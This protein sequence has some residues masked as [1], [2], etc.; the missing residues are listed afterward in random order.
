MQ[1]H[2]ILI[3]SYENWFKKICSWNTGVLKS[4]SFEFDNVESETEEILSFVYF[5]SHHA[6]DI[7][8][9]LH[10][11]R[12]VWFKNSKFSLDINVSIPK[13]ILTLLFFNRYAKGC[14]IVC[15]ADHFDKP[16]LEL[17]Q[18]MKQLHKID[19]NKIVDDT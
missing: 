6:I 8:G 3:C 5:F 17:N 12:S 13:N 11:S 2:L 4:Y 1:S 19:H 10:G 7:H 14:W 18:F 9:D 15:F 16:P